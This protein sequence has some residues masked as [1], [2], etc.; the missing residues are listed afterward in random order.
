MLFN[1]SSIRHKLGYSSFTTRL[2]LLYFL[3]NFWLRKNLG[4]IPRVETYLVRFAFLMPLACALCVLLW[5]HVVVV[6]V[7]VV[8]LVVVGNCHDF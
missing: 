8:L 3:A 2:F 5:A 7:V 6:V 4:S 1:I